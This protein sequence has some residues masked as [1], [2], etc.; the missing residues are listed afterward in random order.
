[1]KKNQ[2]CQLCEKKQEEKVSQSCNGH[3]LTWKVCEPCGDYLRANHNV[4]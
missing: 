1:M 2:K 3:A 4:A